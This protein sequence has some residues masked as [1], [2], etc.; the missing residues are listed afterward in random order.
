M[1][2]KSLKF[3]L[4]F[5]FIF[6]YLGCVG[7]ALST[8]A[9]NPPPQDQVTQGASSIGLMM[10]LVNLATGHL[11]KSKTYIHIIFGMLCISVRFSLEL[12]LKDKR[13]YYEEL[14]LARQNQIQV[15]VPEGQYQLT[16]KKMTAPY[17]VVNTEL[18]VTSQNSE[19]SITACD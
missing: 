11:V 1:K 17:D 2:T 12:R 7:P 15:N 16:L 9:K 19:Y 18:L 5:G 4:P 3:L 13:I 10:N 14:V 8:D 6:I